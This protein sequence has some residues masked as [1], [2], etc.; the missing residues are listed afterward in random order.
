MPAVLP[1]RTSGL[2]TKPEKTMAFSRISRIRALA[3]LALALA[4]AGCANMQ[5]H[6]KLATEMQSA[7]SNGG[8]PAAIARLAPC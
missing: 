3:P 6:D 5:S 8:V 7:G 4:L 1:W 2:T